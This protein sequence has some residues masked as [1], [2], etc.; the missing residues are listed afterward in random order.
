M[1]DHHRDI[2]IRQLAARPRHR[3]EALGKGPYDETAAARGLEQR[4]G[5]KRGRQGRIA[6]TF[7]AP[8]DH[9]ELD[10]VAAAR[11]HDRV[12]PRPREVGARD[13][14][15]AQRSRV[16][17]GGAEDREPGARPYRFRYE[18]QQ[19]AGQHRAQVHRRRPVGDEHRGVAGGPDDGFELVGHPAQLAA[20]T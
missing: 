19:G 7:D 10:H 20:R 18:V 2:E 17:E 3:Q 9:R 4:L 6:R 13:V 8:V 15:G 16:G 1:R 5:H 12:D 11:R 14:G